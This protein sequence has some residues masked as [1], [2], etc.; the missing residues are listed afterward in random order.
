M[1]ALAD[2]VRKYS[3][4]IFVAMGLVWAI[5]SFVG[6]SSLL[7]WPTLTALASGALLIV[8]PQHRFTSALSKASALYGLVL[9]VYQAYV[10]VP[11]LGTLFTSI[12]TYSVASFALIALGNLALLAAGSPER[13][14][15]D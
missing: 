14:A 8:R 4:Y 10:A 5:L 9:A 7:L 15:E 13:V 1:P 12:A 3:A 6:G 11:L 2:F